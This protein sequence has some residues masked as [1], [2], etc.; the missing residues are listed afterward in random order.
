MSKVVK[1][2]DSNFN[3]E[4]MKSSEPVL[5]DFSAT[6]C[7]PCKQLAPLV[8]EIAEEYQGRLKVGAVDVEES[9]STSVRFGVMSV[10]TLILLKNGEVRDQYIGVM[11]K[12]RLTDWISRVF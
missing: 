12:G 4:V 11:P 9:P 8:E 7:G 5:L 10:P 3:D 1:V 2:N 6:W